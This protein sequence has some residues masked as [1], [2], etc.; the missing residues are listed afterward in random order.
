MPQRANLLEAMAYLCKNYPHQGELSK[1]RVNKMLYL[2]DW[3]SAITRG[4]QIT[5]TQWYFN[6][7]GPYVD[8]VR[9]VA[10]EN[11]DIF[12]MKNTYNV[13]GGEKQV[14]HVRKERR[15]PRSRRKTERLSIS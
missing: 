4:Y 8:D 11:K 2:A 12:E 6:W 14:I 3:K 1:A 13:F 7:H 10:A 15:T 5:P 9:I